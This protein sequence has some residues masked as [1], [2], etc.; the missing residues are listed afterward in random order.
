MKKYLLSTLAAAGLFGAAVT[1]HASDDGLIAMNMSN[2][3]AVMQ[4]GMGFG[5]QS[6]KESGVFALGGGYHL[7]RFL[8]S[9]LTVGL[10]AWGKI[11]KSG[12]N[13]DV[14]T[15]PALMNVYASMPYKQ[16]EPYIMGGIGAAW[17][18]ADN[19]SLTKGD[20]KMSFAW[21]MGAGIGY[22]LSDCWSLDLGYRFAD[23]GEA[24]AKFKDGS[25]RIKRDVKSHDVLLSA[26]YYF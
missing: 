12:Y 5:Y 14:W 19:S 21:T 16:F 2:G 7:N 9:D 26:R 6:Y 8:K 15:V 20:D 25:G 11:K 1:A 18:K 3:Y 13:A 23:L 10:R 17:N 24:R 22:R 4:A